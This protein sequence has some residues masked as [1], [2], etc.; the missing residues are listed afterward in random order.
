MH[1]FGCDEQG[2]TR[3]VRRDGHI[4]TDDARSN[5]EPPLQRRPRG[6]GLLGKALIGHHNALYGPKEEPPALVVE[7]DKNRD[8]GPIE[9]HLDEAS[10]KPSW[11][12]LRQPPS[13]P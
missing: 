11:A 7:Y 13:D 5:A 9:L 8:P 3:R 6:G 1:C 12:R 2:N 4:V 10:P